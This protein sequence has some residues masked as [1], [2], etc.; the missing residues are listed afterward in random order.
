VQAHKREPLC[1]FDQACINPATL[2][3]QLGG[4]PVYLAGCKTLLAL[5]GPTYWTRLWCV[6]EMLVHYEM[7]AGKERVQMMQFGFGDSGGLSES[8]I[9]VS[10]ASATDP[11]DE[12]KL[13]AVIEGSGEGTCA[14]NEW[15]RNLVRPN[16]SAASRWSTRPIST[17]LRME[18]RSE[19]SS[20]SASFKDD[21]EPRHTRADSVR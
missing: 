10:K 19:R 13:R 5:V 11:G 14:L 3:A 4:L 8:D 17:P 2:Q 21:R 12:E 16:I 6:I 20:R 9:D 7:G 1:W 15:V 18:A